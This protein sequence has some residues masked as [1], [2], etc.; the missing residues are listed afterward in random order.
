MALSIAARVMICDG[1][2]PALTSS[3]TRR[4]A[5]SAASSFAGSVAGI[6]FR[7]PG[8]I[9]RNSRAVLIVFAVNW[10]PQAP[11][12]GHDASSIS[13]SSSRLI[14]PARY[15]PIASNTVTTV[16][17]RRP[18]STPGL[19]VP[20]Y[21]A[22]PGRSRRASAIAAP[23]SVLSQPTR[24]TR[25]SKRCPRATSSIESAITSRDTSEAFIPSV[26]IETPSETAIV[27]NSIGVPPA[28]RMPSL[29]FTAS[30]RW[31]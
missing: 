18:R 20:L 16:A 29:T 26:P 3:M 19:I 31:L 4:P 24:H 13:R 25:P 28:A 1:R 7:P 17:S 21:R 10:P 5:A 6:P 27:L 15:A 8:L 12:P 22:R 11:G 30:S 9:P 23:G 2:V 14:F